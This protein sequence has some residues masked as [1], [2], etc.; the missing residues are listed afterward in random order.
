CGSSASEAQSLGCEWDI[1]SFAWLP[2]SCIDHETTEKFRA[3][4]PWRYY[5]DVGQTVEISEEQFSQDNVTVYLTNEVHVAHCAYSWVK[6]HRAI[7]LGLK[8][9]DQLPLLHTE[10]CSMVLTRWGDPNAIR[11]RAVIQYPKC[12]HFSSSFPG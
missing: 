11:T 9:H 5:G 6:F 2:S 12:G 10:H 3:A 4:G 1:L 8:V 7:A